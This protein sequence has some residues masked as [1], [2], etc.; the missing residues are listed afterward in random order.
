M[1]EKKDLKSQVAD[2]LSKEGY[3]LEFKAANIFRRGGF[4]VYQGTYVPDFKSGNP[5]ELDI[6]ADWNADVERSFLRISYVVE[7]KWTANKPW[8]I[9]TDPSAQISPGACVAQSIGSH[10]AQS[11]LWLLANDRKIQNLPIFHVPFRPGFNGRQAFGNQGDLVYSTLQSVMSAC[12]SK[13]K[14]YDAYHTDAESHLGLAVAIFPIIVINGE[15]FESYYSESTGEIELEEKD[16]I[17]LHWKGSEAWQFHST[18]DIVTIKHLPAYVQSLQISTGY[19]SERMAGVFSC[20]KECIENKSLDP[21]QDMPRDKR[22]IVNVPP[23]LWP[24]R[25]ELKATNAPPSTSS[26]L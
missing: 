21:L 26:P 13:K 19:L 22:D 6:V 25:D 14:H 9:F 16:M 15:L 11:I 7:C 10:A 20:I 5:R 23:I 24:L 3:P 4:A 17:R 1:Q 12:Y 8:V 2:W 18:I